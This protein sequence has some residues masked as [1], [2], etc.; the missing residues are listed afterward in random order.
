MGQRMQE[1]VWMNH[2]SQIQRNEYR[3]EGLS[4][5]NQV[6][7]DFLPHGTLKTKDHLAEFA[8]IFFLWV[9]FFIILIAATNYPQ[10]RTQVNAIVCYKD[11]GFFVFLCAQALS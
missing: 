6:R 8:Q 3:A 10:K 11:Q 9:R 5:A 7:Q 4:F 2:L 1:C